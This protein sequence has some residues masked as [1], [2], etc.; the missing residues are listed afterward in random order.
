MEFIRQNASSGDF[1]LFIVSLREGSMAQETSPTPF[2]AELLSVTMRGGGVN[3]K[4]KTKI[5]NNFLFCFCIKNM[6]AVKLVSCG[7]VKIVISHICGRIVCG[8]FYS[9]FM[10]ALCKPCFL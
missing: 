10:R 8:C 9:M 2:D 4:Q 6:L 3:V 1:Y 7:F 5:I